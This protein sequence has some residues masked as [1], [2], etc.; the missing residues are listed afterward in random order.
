MYIKR[1]LRYLFLIWVLYSLSNYTQS[2]VS[3]W[4]LSALEAK[5]MLS[6][7]NFLFTFNFFVNKKWLQN[8][9]NPSAKC[10]IFICCPTRLKMTSIS[11]AGFAVRRW[12]NMILRKST[13]FSFNV[14]NSSTYKIKVISRF[15][16]LYKEKIHYII[17]PY[18]QCSYLQI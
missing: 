14:P 4:A 2:T 9:R 17:Y 12:L 7:S 5:A 13:T 8:N 1:I 11:D 16:K 6:F 3:D 10:R 18:L 15:K